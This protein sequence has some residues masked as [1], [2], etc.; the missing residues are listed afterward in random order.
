MRIRGVVGRGHKSQDRRNMKAFAKFAYRLM[1]DSIRYAT[2]RHSHRRGMFQ[3]FA[4]ANL[5]ASGSRTG[6]N[7]GDLAAEFRD[8][9]S[10]RLDSA[11]YPVLF[12]LKRIATDECA[13]LDFGG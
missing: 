9:L 2:F 11:E 6:Y 1:R 12:H 8:A 13:L 5:A 4:E 3:S 7:H 10:L